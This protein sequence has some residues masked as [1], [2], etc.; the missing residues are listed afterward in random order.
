M[1]V[2][3]VLDRHDDM[4][5]SGMRHPSLGEYVAGFTE[6]GLLTCYQLRLFVNTGYSTDHGIGVCD[7]CMCELNIGY[8][9]HA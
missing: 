2:R 1:P 7:Y 5:F 4:M 9:S 6:E 8:I 3:V